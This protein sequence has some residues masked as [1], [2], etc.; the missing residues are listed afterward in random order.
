M[1]DTPPPA[2]VEA[3]EEEIVQKFKLP[4]DANNKATK[5]NILSIARPHMRAF[6]F[7][8]F[9]FFLAFFGWFAVAPLQKQIRDNNEWLQ[10]KR[11]KY[12]NIISVAGTIFMRLLIGP[13]CDTYGPRLAQTILLG[14]FSIP[15]FLIGTARNYA[16]WTTARFFIGFIGA[17]FVVTQFWTSVMFSG[18]IVGTANATSGGWGN[19]GGG[20]TQAVMPAIRKGISSARGNTFGK[21]CVATEEIK[22]DKD[23]DTAWR[24]AVVI[25]A[26]SLVLFAAIMFFF[27]DDVPE[28]NY[29]DLKKKGGK[30]VNGAKSM[31]KAVT[32]W[33]VWI[34][35][36]IYGGCFGV[37]LLM[38]GN[39][40][41]YFSGNADK[42]GNLREAINLSEGKAGLIAS[43]F[44]LMNLFA[45]TTGGF[46]SDFF[47]KRWGIRGRLSLRVLRSCPSPR[48]ASS[49]L[50]RPF[51]SPSPCSCRWR[52]APRSELFPSLTPKRSVPSPV[53]SV[54]A[55]TQALSPVVS[56]S[57]PVS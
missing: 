44:G 4:V 48:P 17:T 12:Q 40:A 33:R 56:S 37:E 31:L 19:L 16:A 24:I 41:T 39:L 47:N 3:A 5:L 26:A 20:V 27:S 7:A 6:H 43:L 14:A 42:E 1:G 2:D 49:A 50:P 18:N 22:C 8:W 34:L 28:G 15:L 51:L 45:R 25:P 54:P 46:G 10:G 32:N 53:S 57:T 11:F 13:F 29:S 52:K 55:V 36:L 30:T 21:D 38:N 9:S 23:D 35:F